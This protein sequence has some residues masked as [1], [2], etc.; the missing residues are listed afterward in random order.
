MILDTIIIG[1]GVAGMTAALYALRANKKVL[2]LEANFYGGQILQ[3]PLIEN[4]P[5]LA[6]VSGESFSNNLYMQLKELGLKITYQKVEKIS[7]DEGKQVYQARTQKQE[8]IGRT[9]ILA[10]GTSN[11]KL[12]LPREEQLIG[13]GVAFCA[14][15]DG[16]LYRNEPVAVVGGG[17]SAVLSALHL[18]E[19][20]SDVFLVHRREKLRA[21]DLLIKKIKKYQNIHIIYNNEVVS[22]VQSG[23]RLSGVILK[24]PVRGLVFESR[25][26]LLR[27]KMQNES[28]IRSSNEEFYDPVQRILYVKA[29]FIEIGRIFPSEDILREMIEKYEIQTD[30]E[31]FI[32]TDESCKTGLAGFFVAGDCRSKDVRQLVTATAD[33]ALAANAMINFLN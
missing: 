19:L 13:K 9:I 25:K 6:N 1:A 18:A 30:S 20:C 22:L 16:A 14:T 17:N 32:K 11:R 8:Y 26:E 12:S 10:T 27:E 15:C 3:T 29:L 4:Y 31:G 21:E 7:F 5:A 24:N 2:L 33:G 23:D 28:E